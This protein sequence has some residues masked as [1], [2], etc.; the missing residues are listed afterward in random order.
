M[1]LHGR[2]VAELVVTLMDFV[3]EDLHPQAARQRTDHAYPADAELRRD[4][5]AAV[6]VL[7]R[8]PRKP[9]GDQPACYGVWSLAAV[10]VAG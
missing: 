7:A 5:R 1:A 9:T 3:E 2:L 8:W 6:T 10:A 4:A